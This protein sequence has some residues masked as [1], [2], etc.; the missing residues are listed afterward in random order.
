MK[1][2][3]QE[4]VINAAPQKIWE[5]L[6]NV[7]LIDKWGGGPAVMDDKVNTHFKLWDG[8]IF[9][10]NIEAI[11]FKK[12]KQE[13]YG[14]KWDKPSILTFSISEEHGKTK[15]TLV[16]EDVPD[17]EYKDVEEGWKIYYMNPLKELVEKEN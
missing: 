10:K 4:Y 1:I 3:K 7:D 2:L 6:T 15:V 5:A 11:P 9:G 14:G 8:E 17:E 13:W 16:Q 12:L